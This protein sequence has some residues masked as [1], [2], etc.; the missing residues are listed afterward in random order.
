MAV[1][2]D[3]SKEAEIERIKNEFISTVSH[4]LR[5]PMTSVKGYADL[6][7]SG[8]AHV[9]TLN[10]TQ[11]R[12]VE[13]IQANANRLT[14]LVNEILEISRIETGR[15]K[16]QLETIDL[17]ALLNEVTLSFEGQLVQK[18][19]DLEVTLPD[20]PPYVYA[21]KGRLTQILVNLIGNAWQYTPERGRITIE[22][23]ATDDNYVQ[24]DIKDTGIGIPEQDLEYV[25]ERF[26]RSERPEAQVVDGTGLGL[27]IT[28][29]YVDMLGGKIWVESELN[30]GTTFSFTM[31][32]KA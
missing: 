5:T 25:F 27:S 31:P 28:K 8:N 11:R 17:A 20:E 1:L 19:M 15:V 30:V 22:V 21:D 29:S 32:L 23:T 12:F 13:V 26:F 24:I 9:G 18:A 6:L 2:R 16:L 7:V 10:P 4:E 3:I 14:D